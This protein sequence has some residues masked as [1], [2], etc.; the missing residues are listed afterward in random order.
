MKYLWEAKP[1]FTR[2]DVFSEGW[3]VGTI[4]CSDDEEAIVWARRMMAKHD[5]GQQQVVKLIQDGRAVATL[6]SQVNG[7]PTGA[8]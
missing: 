4:N 7:R 6:R 8:A 2:P 1:H 3:E 5:A